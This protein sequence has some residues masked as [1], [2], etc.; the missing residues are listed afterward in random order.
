[1]QSLTEKLNEIEKSAV[2]FIAVFAPW[3]GPIPSA[4]LVGNAAQEYLHWPLL[5]AIIAGVAVEAIGVVS[6]VLALRLYEW[7][8]TKNKTDPGAPF[9]LA[10]VLVAV[11]FVVTIGLTVLLDVFPDLARYAPAIFPLLAA[12][13]AVNIA[14]KNGQNRREEAKAGR[15]KGTKVSPKVSPKVSGNETGATFANWRKI[16]TETKLEMAQMTP[17]QIQ[18]TYGAQE[19]TAQNWAKNAREL[20]AKVSGNGYLEHS[21]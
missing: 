15:K 10:V 7:N 5:I 12:V 3:L 19:R 11:Y 16:P 17:A 20:A 14:V 1:M 9:G 18:E 6:V 2:D 4:W 8:D 21:R 13:G